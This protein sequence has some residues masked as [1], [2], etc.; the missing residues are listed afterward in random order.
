MTALNPITLPSARSLL[1]VFRF[2]K[3]I[4]KPFLLS[5]GLQIFQ[6]YAT[7]YSIEALNIAVSQV[8]PTKGANNNSWIYHLF[9]N[10]DSGKAHIILTAVSVALA[11]VFVG[12]ICDIIVAWSISW[13]FALLN[14]SLT[15][16]IMRQLVYS[17]TTETVKKQEATVVQRWLIIREI[18][19]FFHNV[20]AN[21][22]G[23]IFT[24]GVLIWGT[25]HQNTMG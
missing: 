21:T 17:Q 9:I 10:P 22:L 5:I 3:Y 4:W 8:D 24:I 20:V 12:M 6:S 16:Q 7:L 14:D 23:S 15:A 1:R 13:S 18:A 25:Y 2:F 11:I 19:E